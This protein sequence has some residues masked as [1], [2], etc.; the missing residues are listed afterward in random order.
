M[1]NVQIS[2]SDQRLPVGRQLTALVRLARLTKDEGDAG[3]QI[4]EVGTVDRVGN[5]PLD[6]RLNCGSWCVY[7]KTAYFPES[8]RVITVTGSQ[9]TQMITLELASTTGKQPRQHTRVTNSQGVKDDIFYRQ[10]SPSRAN[11][12][13]GNS[14]LIKS[15]DTRRG[16][17]NIFVVHN[18]N[19]NSTKK[20]RLP[21]FSDLRSFDARMS[22]WMGT[23]AEQE[24]SA[25]VQIWKDSFTTDCPD[26]VRVVE[27][28]FDPSKS[29]DLNFDRKAILGINFRD[30]NYSVVL[31]PNQLSN[32]SGLASPLHLEI[33][34]IDESID[35]DTDANRLISVRLH[36]CDPTFDAVTQFLADGQTPNAL[37]VWQSVADD[38]M[39]SRK[40]DPVTASAATI[41][42]IHAYLS[43]SIAESYVTQWEH[44][45]ETL[46]GSY[47]TL[48]DS[49]IGDAWIKALTSSDRETQIKSAMSSFENAVQRGLPVFTEAIRLLSRG[50][51]WAYEQDRHSDRLKAIRWLTSHVLPGNA[52]TTI[53]HQKVIND[54]A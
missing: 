40:P 47:K 22:Y 46:D 3:E 13:T 31:P 7:V 37:K 16:N 20:V 44:L 51:E 10:L 34:F 38:L 4:N 17:S 2:F 54:E 18:Y 27:L 19:Y 48:S 28:R 41:M 39:N 14:A 23:W 50:A 52:L 29:K 30:Q 26:N 35:C 21:Q 24:T 9:K 25:P 12:G 43:R 45:V 36:T 33:S 6:M 1:P 42:L 49:A 8:V 15:K 32:S 11:A 5:F 53:R